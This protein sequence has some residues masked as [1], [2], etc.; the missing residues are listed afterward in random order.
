MPLRGRTSHTTVDPAPLAR[1]LE[2]GVVLTEWLDPLF[3]GAFFVVDVDFDVTAYRTLWFGLQYEAESVD[4]A[5]VGDG[6]L[7]T[8]RW[9]DG[10][11]I[12]DGYVQGVFQGLK[13]VVG[14]QIDRSVFSHEAGSEFRTK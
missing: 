12:D 8:V 10:E 14:S 2:L 1:A 7:R 4:D 3:H 5:T 11:P 6:A 9:Y 13:Q